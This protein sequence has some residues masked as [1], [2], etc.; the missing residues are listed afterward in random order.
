VAVLRRAGW[1]AAVGERPQDTEAALLRDLHEAREHLAATTEVL[2][3]LG[4]AGS[5]VDAILG[6]VV[7]NARQLC[8]ADAAL[9]YLL[10]RDVYTLARASGASDESWV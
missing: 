8:R 1:G 5:D 9:I 4:R 7:D 2:A 3:V 10:D 6:A